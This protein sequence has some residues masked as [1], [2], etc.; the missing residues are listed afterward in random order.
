MIALLKLAGQEP[1]SFLDEGYV[2]RKA[3][4]LA[5]SSDLT[6]QVMK[7]WKQND[8]LSVRFDTDMPIVS[9][10]ANGGVVRHRFLKVELHDA[11][12]DVDTNFATRSAGFQ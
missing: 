4:L 11:R 10:A 6:R 8:A 3:E 5:A 12:H 2:T 9:H 1:K 7:Y